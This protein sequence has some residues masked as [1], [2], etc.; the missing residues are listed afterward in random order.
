MEDRLG[1]LSP[2]LLHDQRNVVQ[3]ILVARYLAF[4]GKSPAASTAGDAD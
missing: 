2:Q 1:R 3:S 4:I